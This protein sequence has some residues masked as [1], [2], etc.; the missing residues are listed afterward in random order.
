M[1]H[2]SLEK[3]GDGYVQEMALKLNAFFVRDA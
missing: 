3:I 1:I 2:L